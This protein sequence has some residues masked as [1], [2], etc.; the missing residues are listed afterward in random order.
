MRRI[1][2]NRA[3]ADNRAALPAVHI[4]RTQLMA[5]FADDQR[6]NGDLLQLAMSFELEP[7]GE[8]GPDH[9]AVMFGVGRPVALGFRDDI[10]VGGLGPIRRSGDLVVLQVVGVDEQIH[11]GSCDP[12]RRHAGGGT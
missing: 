7:I 9:F 6:I 2:V 8:Q 3:G 10:E 12:S 1:G 5:V 11:Q 4:R